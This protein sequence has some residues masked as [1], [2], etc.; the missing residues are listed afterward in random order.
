MA[1]VDSL[2]EIGKEFYLLRSEEPEFHRNIYFKRFIG[3]DG[4]Q[5]NMIMDPGTKLDL[6][7][8]IAAANHLFGG[9]QNLDIIFVSH[10]DPDLTSNLDAILT[11]APKALLLA[12][13]D[14]WRL[15]RM[16]GLPDNR[17]K[18]IEDFRTDTL[19]IR[20]TGH[21]IK[22][23]PA[24]YCHFR[25]AMMVYDFE[26]RVLFTGDFMGGTDTRKGPGV[27][28]TEESW[29][30]IAMFHSIYM[31]TN[32]VVRSTI[33]RI[34]MLDPFPEV[35]APQHGDVIKGDLVYDFLGRLMELDVGL[36]LMEKEKP[37]KETL[38]IAVNEFLDKLKASNAPVYKVILARLK[39]PG[40][41]TTPFYV[42]AE[43]VV[44]VKVDVNDALRFL[45]DSIDEKIPDVSTQRMVKK[46]LLSTLKQYD[47]KLPFKVDITLEEETPP[48]ADKN[49]FLDSFS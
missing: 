5:V 40:K 37:E 20:K 34:G 1:I 23:V 48:E 21:L 25:G 39:E 3:P 42:P 8:V 18:A 28:A 6:S 49:I 14:S 24:Y 7:R 22:F 19:K 46:L 17:F 45:W 2:H 9:L 11:A 27:Y 41:F 10:Q 31:P 33:D 32:S 36:D 12:S 15:I 44:D 26:S 16:Y 47:I 38:V 29:P 4:S 43:V 13:I 30:G 35:I